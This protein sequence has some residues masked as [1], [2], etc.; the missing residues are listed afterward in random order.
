MGFCLFRSRP[1]SAVVQAFLDRTIGQHGATPKYL[2]SDKGVQFWC[3]GYKAWCRLRGIMPRFGAVGQHGSIA[4]V[5]RFIRTLK[6]EGTQRILVP[7]RRQVLRGQLTWFL[8]WYNEMRPHMSLGG[9]TPNEVYHARP[10]ANQQARIEPRPY[11][12]AN[13]PCARPR[14]A[15]DGKTGA[16]FHLELTNHA[17]Q[18]HLPIVTLRRAA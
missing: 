13:A 8:E 17:D 14:V 5:E 3:L 16:V 18:K 6:D 1:K 4:V 12:P 9:K 15:V 7:Q 11:W 10:P 2:I